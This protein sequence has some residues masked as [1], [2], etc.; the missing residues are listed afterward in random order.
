MALSLQM[1]KV[2]YPAWAHRLSMNSVHQTSCNKKQGRC[3][4][5]LNCY[6]K[7]YRLR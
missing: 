1:D 7:L 6:P 5:R 4:E 3:A 2:K